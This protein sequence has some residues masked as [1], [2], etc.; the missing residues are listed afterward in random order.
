MNRHVNRGR[1]QA[2][3]RIGTRGL[4]VIA[5]V[6][7]CGAP[8]S[9]TAQKSDVA[10]GYGYAAIRHEFDWKNYQ[11][12]WLGTSLYVRSQLGIVGEFDRLVWSRTYNAS[13]GETHRRYGYLGGVKFTS[14]RDR[15]ASGFVQALAGVGHDHTTLGTGDELELSGSTFAIQ[16]GGGGDFHL[17]QAVSVRTAGDVRI[18]G[19]Q[20]STDWHFPEWRLQA[21]VV[22]GFQ[23]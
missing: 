12:F 4:C 20:H 10:G 5:T 19:P 8:S 1:S 17:T 6:V 7:L 11:G 21:G 16:F 9:A 15:S 13:V 22:Y 14:R 3:S 23:R 18:N 2:A